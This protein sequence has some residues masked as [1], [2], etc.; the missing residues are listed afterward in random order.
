MM[1]ANKARQL[2]WNR[3]IVLFKSGELDFVTIE[4]S[5]QHLSLWHPTRGRLDYWPSTSK[6][7]WINK[8]PHQYF[9]IE[10]IEAYID[11]HFKQ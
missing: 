3:E 9:K 8:K 6:A 4:N 5:D 10:D 11:K 2:K 7:C 1:S